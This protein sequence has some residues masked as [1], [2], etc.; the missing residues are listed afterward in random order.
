MEAKNRIKTKSKNKET[1]QKFNYTVPGLSIAILKSF[2]DGR[3]NFWNRRVGSGVK[4][5]NL[6][7]TVIPKPAGLLGDEQR[8]HWEHSKLRHY[9]PYHT[10][11]VKFSHG[12]AVDTVPE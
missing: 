10:A 12:R 8:D 4:D 3:R 9:H 2:S 1:K 5:L 7:E 11:M 6:I